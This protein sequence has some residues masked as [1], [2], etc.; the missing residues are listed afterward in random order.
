MREP[1]EWA[2]IDLDDDVQLQEV[3]HL[4]TKHYVEDN[5]ASFRFDYSADFIRWALKPPGFIKDWHVGIRAKGS[6][7]LVAF[8]AGVPMELRVRQMTKQC[9]EINYLCVHKKLRANR[10]APLLIQ[11]VTRRCNKA[12][13][14]QAVY[15][16]GIFLPTPISRCQYY[17]RALNPKQ[18][19]A[20]GFTSLPRHQTMASLVK[21]A[22]LPSQTF[23][24]GLREIS[25]ADVNAVCDLLNTQMNR[26]DVA[27]VMSLED[28]RH[29]FISGRGQGNTMRGRRSGQVTWSYVVETSGAIT[30]FFSFYHLPSTAIKANQIVDAAYLFYYAS[31]SCTP[32]TPAMDATASAKRPSSTLFAPVQPSQRLQQLIQ[33]A[34]IIA[35]NA[36]FDVFN[37]LTLMDN[38]LFLRDLKFGPGDGFLHYYLYNWLTRPIDGGESGRNNEG[39]QGSGVGL[40]ML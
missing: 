25:E 36:G 6:K 15:T 31:T 40:V 3:Y 20:T 27:P 35:K 2:S 39:D 22:S 32:S 5:D 18:L 23:T 37:A 7:K 11:E 21:R 12:G 13:I 26:Y 38:N 28:V 33:D 14:F 30:D 4:L 16:A 1:Y 24:S 19:V 10:L 9:S 8:I 29:N 34:L 17:H